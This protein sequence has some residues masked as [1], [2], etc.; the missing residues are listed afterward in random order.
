MN[1]VDKWR[2]HRRMINPLFNVNLIKQFFPVFNEENEI[3]I[4]NLKKE[5]GKTQM[6]NLMDYIDPTNLDTI[7]REYISC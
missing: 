6:F 7:C 5:V 2:V 3:L 1:A 4:K